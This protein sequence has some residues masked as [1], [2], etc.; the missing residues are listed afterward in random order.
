MKQRCRPAARR[1]AGGR[2][3]RHRGAGRGAPRR[4][5][6]G[7]HRR[8]AAGRAGQRAR[9]PQQE[10]LGAGH[11][12]GACTAS[13]RSACGRAARISAC[14]RAPA[15]AAR[16]STCTSARRWRSSSACSRTTCGTSAR[17][18]PETHAA[19]DRGPGLG[20]P[21]AR[22]ACR[23]ATCARRARCWSA[24]TS[25]RARYVA[26]MREC[27]VLP[28]HVSDLLLP[29]RALIGSHG[30][31]RDR[32]PQIELAVR[33]RRHGAGAAPPG[34][35]ERGRPGASCAP[36]R[37]TMPACS[38][39][40]SPRGRTRCSCSTTAAPELA[41]ALPEFGITHAVQADRLHP[42]QPAHQ[43]G[44]GRARAAPAGRAAATSG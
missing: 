3:A 31:D 38:G 32:L 18:K 39:G 5:Q 19:A 40:C 9:Q 8:R 4:R 36:S 20:L 13:R 1:L 44:A 11:A 23:C 15:A 27:Q 6:G 30:R 7:V 21:L 25:A 26:D 14:T 17:C 16:C 35:A 22:A 28:P 42:G 12:D 29:L 2:V 41:Y 37:A 33:R 24:F 43:P 10:Q 34:A